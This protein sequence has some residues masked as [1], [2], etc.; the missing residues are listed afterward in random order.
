MWVAPAIKGAVSDFNVPRP[1]H[2][3]SL[4]KRSTQIRVSFSSVQ[5]GRYEV[6]AVVPFS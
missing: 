3:K 6:V 4:T 5:I 2:P 1:V